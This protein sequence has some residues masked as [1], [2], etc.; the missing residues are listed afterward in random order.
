VRLTKLRQLPLGEFRVQYAY[1]NFGL[2][3]AAEAVAAAN[4]TSW[5]ALSQS[6]LYDPLEMNNTSSLYADYL[7]AGNRAIT[8]Q[9]TENG[10]LP[11][12]SRN[13]DAQS[14]AGSV[15]SSVNDMAKWLEP[16]MANGSYGGEDLIKPEVLQFKRQSHMT[17]MLATDPAARSSMYGYGIG[18]GVD[19]TGHVRWSHIGA[20]ALDTATSLDMLP[21]AELGIVVLTKG[22]PYGLPEVVNAAFLDIVETGQVQRDW[23]SAFE[24]LLGPLNIND[25]QL[26]AATPSATRNQ[27][28]PYA[29]M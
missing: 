16:Q 10:W 2:T 23:L 24:S 5:A 21:V 29:L 6:K 26:A 22:A 17:S 1:T 3:A 4:Q 27:P 8:H 18:S 19:G 11:G 25:S 14:P 15:S 28:N 7:S 13:P 12:E 9:R 20:F